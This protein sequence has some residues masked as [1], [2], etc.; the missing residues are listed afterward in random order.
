MK[1]YSVFSSV[2]FAI[3]T[4]NKSSI[5]VIKV[6]QMQDLVFQEPKKKKIL[7]KRGS[8]AFHPYDKKK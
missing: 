6:P 5:S 3:E 2:S 1:A 4:V 7:Q 8:C